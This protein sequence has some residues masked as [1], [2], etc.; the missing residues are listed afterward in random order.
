MP[1]QP[2]TVQ[3]QEAV[4]RKFLN[5]VSITGYASLA[6]GT[7]SVVTAANK[8]IKAHKYLAYIAGALAFLHTGIVEGRKIAFK[9]GTK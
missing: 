8:K 4:K 5:P 7:A 9:K 1:I 2:I 6:C 3:P